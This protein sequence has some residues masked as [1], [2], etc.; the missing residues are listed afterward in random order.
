M[1]QYLY[2]YQ[3]ITRFQSRVASH[4][5]ILRC[6]PCSDTRQKVIKSDVTI[7]PVTSVS[8]NKDFFGS[9]VFY[10]R[11]PS[12][13]D[14]FG[15]IST[16]IVQIEDSLEA[17]SNPSVIYRMPSRMTELPDKTAK[18]LEN[19]LQSESPLQA[20]KEVCD[21]VH[22][23]MEYVPGSTGVM[24]TASEALSQGKGVCQDFAHIMIGICRKM[25]ILC[26]YVCGL[27]CGEGET[28]AWVEV[29][30]EGLWY[31]FDPTAGSFDAE[32]GGYIKIAHGRDAYDC[33]VNRGVFTGASSEQTET[34]VV[35]EKI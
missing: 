26:R 14:K 10:G 15:Y 31:P 6:E 29:W 7:F 3:S 32:A 17:D 2:S 1:R 27:V 19:M 20:A 25:G 12:Y 34:K 23:K 16:G 35:V 28:H 4:S 5:W 13:H 18:E 8:E 11:I 30:H 9:S 22:G 33:P 24:T 21:Y